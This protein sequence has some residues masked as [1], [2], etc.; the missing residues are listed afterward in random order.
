MKQE[1]FNSNMLGATQADVT[2]GGTSN[3]SLE[4]KDPSPESQ[5]QLPSDQTKEATP[6]TSKLFFLFFFLSFV[7]VLFKMQ[8]KFHSV[9]I[10]TSSQTSAVTSSEQMRLRKK[11]QNLNRSDSTGSSS[12]RKFLAPTLSDPQTLRSDKYGSKKK[13]SSFMSGGANVAGSSGVTTPTGSR[14]RNQIL[15]PDHAVRPKNQ[16]LRPEM[17]T[18]SEEY[19]DMASTSMPSTSNIATGAIAKHTLPPLPTDSSNLHFHATTSQSMHGFD[20]QSSSP[21]DATGR[22][23]NLNNNS[24]STGSNVGPSTS[25]MANNMMGSSTSNTNVAYEVHDWWTD[26]VN[27]QSSDEDDEE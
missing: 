21:Y 2:S 3:G 15:Q 18:E 14:P 17:T 10:A 24:S 11:T 8:K 13:S 1:L 26:Q 7:V 4:K 5:E 16:A 9:Q 25:K 27:V 23:S 12:G 20:L 6:S 22:S 19:E